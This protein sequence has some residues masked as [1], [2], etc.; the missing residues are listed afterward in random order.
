MQTQERK[1]VE[2]LIKIYTGI[3]FVI[4]AILIGKLAWMQLWQGEV[5]QSRAD[6]NRNRLMTITAKRGDIVASDGTV[7]VTD[8][9][10][11]QVVLNNQVVR[12]N[13]PVIE[14]LAEILNDET[15]T[16]EAIQKICD[17]N[18]MRLYQPIVLKKNID[19]ET[20]SKLEARRSELDGVSIEA[21]SN[22]TYLQGDLASHVLGYIGEVSQTELDAQQN[23]ESDTNYQLGDY[24]G[25][26]GLEKYYDLVLRGVDGYKQVEV[27]ANNRPLSD[28]RT[29]EPTE[30]NNLVLTI[31]YQLQKTLEE[32]MDANIA[33]LQAARR[34][35]KAGNGAAVVLDVNSGAVLAMVSRPADKVTQQNRAIQGRYIPGSTFKPVTATAALESG[36]VTVTEKIR[37]PGR[38]WKAPYIKSTAPVGNYS[39]Y[40]AMAKSDNVYFQEIGRRAG[41]ANI[42]KYG[43]EYGLDSPT[44]IDLAYE[45][46]GERVS[47]G[48]PTESKRDAYHQWAATVWAERYDQKIAAAEVEY[49]ALLAA[50]SEEEKPA[51]EK[52]RRNAIAKLEADKLINV[53]WNSEWHEAD[54]YNVAI[55][56]GR[57]NYT[58]IQMA[59]YIATIANGGTV[60]QPYLVQ[61][62]RDNQGNILQETTP[63]VR[64]QADISSETLAHIQR[65]LQAVAEPGGGAYSQFASFPADLKVA[66]KTGT[67]QPG[68]SGYRTS[69]QQYYDG[70]FV[71]YAPADDP[72]IAFVSVLEYGYSGAG[73]GGPICRA[74]FQEYFGLN[75]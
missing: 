56:Q 55:G 22:R 31:D 44:G 9:P 39:L 60:Y 62:I 57:Q 25:K 37:N 29:V 6:S 10:S 43:A 21:K 32:A 24:V 12:G 19:M 41:I 13:T 27:D 64:H 36:V 54:T 58:P 15:L 72:Q 23:G 18:R 67:A 1:R 30:G 50:A 11:Y 33:R 69:S 5:Y 71:A 38:Y 75:Q 68:G 8:R 17:D 52:R 46:Q 14:T 51:I 16:A 66:A 47:E 49:A 73:S 26:V 40:S 48:L 59:V 42:G 3:I 70:V 28:I 61:E 63:T 53:K 74:V 7:L 65:A 35:D 2:Q 4:V 34:S 45:N 20:V